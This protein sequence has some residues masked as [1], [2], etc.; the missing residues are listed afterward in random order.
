MGSSLTH[1]PDLSLTYNAAT[2]QRVNC[3]KSSLDT[4]QAAAKHYKPQDGVFI[5]VSDID[6]DAVFSNFNSKLESIK[7][8]QDSLASTLDDRGSI[9]T[10]KISLIDAGS[11]SSSI[12]SCLEF[13]RNL[14]DTP[15]DGVSLGSGLLNQ[16]KSGF[17]G[18]LMLSA[19]TLGLTLA[20][21][22]VAAALYGGLSLGNEHLNK[23]IPSGDKVAS[24]IIDAAHAFYK[25]GGTTDIGGLTISIPSSVS[26]T[27]AVQAS[28]TSA[29]RVLILVEHFGPVVAAE[30]IRN[31]LAASI[32][33]GDDTE[34]SAAKELFK[35]WEVYA[36]AKLSTKVVSESAPA[37]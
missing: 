26:R 31:N 2:E 10:N 16:F 17:R 30:K 18:A 4:Q 24:T 3:L 11:F 37:I 34:T 32:I 22:S 6:L 7:A 19:K 35:A 36:A 14:R 8:T 25:N 1:A 27:D 29:Q 28:T 9:I 13:I 12:K 15:E 21:V 23:N 20:T 5:K 33:N